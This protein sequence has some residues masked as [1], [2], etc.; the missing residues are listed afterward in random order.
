[1]PGSSSRWSFKRGDRGPFV[2]DSQDRLRQL[3]YDPGGMHGIF[4]LQMAEAVRSFQNAKNLPATGVIDEKTLVLLFELTKPDDLMR[5]LIE[6]G[7]VERERPGA[8]TLTG[9][10]LTGEIVETTEG[11]G[12]AG[13][14]TTGRTIVISVTEHALGLF[15]GKALIRRYPVAVG[16]PLTPTPIG[17]FRILEKVLDPGGALGSRWMGFTPE[18]HGIHGTNMPELIGQEVSHGCVRM[19]NYNVEELFDMVK[20]GTPVVIIRNALTLWNEITPGSAPVPEPGPGPDKPPASSQGPGSGPKDSKDE[21]ENA[22]IVKP[23]VGPPSPG[24]TYVVEPGDTLYRIA[25]RFG[26]TV[27][28]IVKANRIE[29]PDLI[30]PGEVIVIPMNYPPL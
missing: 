30:Y 27:D 1:M 22:G 3:G 25:L 29:N 21:G 6:A 17:R 11:A 12:T 18:Q 14:T 7:G 20:I 2:A 10:A 4:S 13:E 28:A 24:I 23:P 15:E 9:K 16:K 19:Y 8:K 5:G 26:T